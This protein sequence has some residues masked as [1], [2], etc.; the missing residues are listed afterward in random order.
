MAEATV[1]KH[2]F[3]AEIKQL[4]DIVVHSLY[5]DKEIFIR[6]LVSNASDALEK[7]RHLQ[8]VEKE[9]F[10]D[11]LE[12]EINITTDD[13]ANTITFQDFGVGM[14]K[15]ELIENLG[16][17]AHSGSK[18]FLKALKEKEG[19]SE[20]LIGQFGVG[21]Y[22][23]FMVAS[24][25]SVFTH[26]WDNNGEHLLWTSDGSGNFEIETME[27]Q[28]RGCKIIVHLNDD[29]KEYSGA[30]KV[31][32]ILNRYSKYVPFP[33]NLNGEKINSIE[34]LWLKQKRSI[35]KD[36]YI[37]F[38]KFQT[39][40]SE[41]PASW[42]HFNAD[43]PLAINAILFVPSENPERWGFGRIDPEVGLYCKKVL[44]DAKPDGLLPEWLRFLKGVVD[45]ADL[46]LNISRETMQDS[47][48]VQKLNKVLTKRFLKYLKDEAKK[49][50]E[51]YNE[52]YKKF[53]SYLKEG[54]T[55]DFDH[56]DQLS[57]LLLYESSLTEKDKT[58]SLADYV[59][60]MKEG[61]NDIYYIYAKNRK[62]IESGP[63]LEA[64]KARNLE[65]LFL[66]EP[67]D[68]FVMSHLREFDGKK[69]VSADQADLE[70]EDIAD[71]SEG[72]PLEEEKAKALTEWIKGHFGD[73][74]SSVE[75]SKRLVGSPAIALNS[76]KFMT[77]GMRSIMKAMNQEVEGNPTVKLELNTRHPLIKNISDLKD[78]NKEL[79][80]L[81]V[82][83]L[84][85]N[86]LISAGFLEDPRNIV[87]RV[88]KILER[89]SEK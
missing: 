80:E 60:R 83:Q 47:A 39:N 89:V 11:K 70:L 25:V 4:L 36:E 74:V 78:T 87:D 86:A 31:K 73:K 23:A 79:A 69:L 1:E 19:I 59:S 15:A 75:M 65:A 7:M 56:K 62:F 77:S 26:S 71:S 12:L 63:Y 68:E 67:V 10:D 16:T 6:E 57:K 24:R 45:S 33:V 32:E 17:I 27:G 22:S 54:I 29:N 88:Y 61:Q 14:N 2:E 35:K 76:D 28:R 40:T 72:E 64:F 44:I 51:K 49:N 55:M 18:A 20:N 8:K 3:Q 52:F 5:T 38:Y 82:D 58:T 43:V 84:Y 37:E 85:D 46:P 30:D 21:F 66:Y 41:D 42:I 81:V 48:L 50:P 34:A 53:G 13:K 9:I